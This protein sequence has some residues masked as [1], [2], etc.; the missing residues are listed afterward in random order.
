MDDRASVGFICF[1]EINTPIERIR[2]KHDSAIETLSSMC[3]VVDAGVV[4][5]D[6][7]Y[8]TAKIAI[9]KLSGKILCM[10]YNSLRVYMIPS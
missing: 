3:E 7:A 10:S 2:L 5:D 8:E 6:P 9:D 4:V 1:G